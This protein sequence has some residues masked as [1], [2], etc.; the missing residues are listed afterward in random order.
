M[1]G[2]YVM[3]VY[4]KTNILDSTA[5]VVVCLVNTVG[6]MGAGLA[7]AFRLRYPD[8]YQD[9]RLACL[10]SP[11]R[12]EPGSIHIYDVPEPQNAYKRIISFPTKKHWSNPS[13]LE[14]IRD[15]MKAFMNWYYQNYQSVSSVSFP[16]LGCGLGGLDWSNQVYPIIYDCLVDLP[17]LV[18]IHLD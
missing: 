17:L 3:L 13:E 9:Y 14:Y 18:L 4:S 7:R 6:V 16:K 12:L 15:G 1:A 10:Q 8:Y 2:K 11:H 5:D